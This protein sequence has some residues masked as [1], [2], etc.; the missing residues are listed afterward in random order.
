MNIKVARRV[1]EGLSAETGNVAIFWTA[2]QRRE[3]V[4]P[5]K[6]I[7]CSDSSSLF[8]TLLYSHSEDGKDI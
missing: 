6:T 1:N 7:I 8:V 2:L 5:L 3:E 4:K